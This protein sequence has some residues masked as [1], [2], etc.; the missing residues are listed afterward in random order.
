MGRILCEDDG[1]RDGL[2]IATALEM[3]SITHIVLGATVGEALAGRKLGKR[4]M[5]LG[6][7]ANSFPDIDFIGS[8]WMGTARDVWTHRG[9]THSI[10]F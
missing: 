9:I 5:L 7:I 6:A 3:D 1:G 4:A 8:F 2:M 10:L